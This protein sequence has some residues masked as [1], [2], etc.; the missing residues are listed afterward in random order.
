MRPCEA[1][2]PSTSGSLIPSSFA[3]CAERKS[4]AGSRRAQPVTIA[5]WRLASARKRTMALSRLR[6]A[7]RAGQLLCQISGSGM[8]LAERILLAFTSRD[9]LVDLGPVSQVKG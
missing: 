4:I 1:A 6:L 8:R 9:V 2:I 3:L 7:P 5:W